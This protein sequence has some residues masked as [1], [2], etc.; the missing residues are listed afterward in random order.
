MR[1]KI[2]AFIL[3]VFPIVSS[4][5]LEKNRRDFAIAIVAYNR[6]GYLERVLEALASNPES[7]TTPIYFFFDG[8]P[9]ATQNENLKLVQNFNFPFANIILR[10]GNFGCPKNLIEARRHLFDELCYDKVL[11]IEDDNVI[12]PNYITFILNFYNWS[13]NHIKN[14]GAVCGWNQVL[15]SLEEKRA[16]L[17]K[18][19]PNSM[20]NYWAY[21]MDRSCWDE[22]KGIY[23]EYKKLFLEKG[24]RSHYKNAEKIRAWIRRRVITN[25]RYGDQYAELFLRADYGTG[26][27]SVMRLAL[28]EKDLQ[29]ACSQ[30]NRIINIGKVGLNYDEDFWES[31]LKNYSLDYFKEDDELLDF[32]ILY[33]D[34]MDDFKR[35]PEDSLP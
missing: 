23:F 7:T 4:Y 34:L 1:T 28:W 6:P 2:I 17:N 5:A 24:G 21:L 16:A 26:Q 3:F 15:L 25:S 27:D 10:K 31:E 22:I 30:V 35:L 13:K 29:C 11:I 19:V 14:V 9:E 12:S 33:A 18:I 8:G 32:V 20:W